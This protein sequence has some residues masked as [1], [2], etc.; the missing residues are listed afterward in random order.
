MSAAGERRP[1][2]IRRKKVVHRHHGGSWKIA[3]ADFMTALMALFLVMWILSAASP[4][5]REGVAEYFRTPLVTAITGGDRSSSSA[6]VIPGGGPDPV[7]AEG[8]RA[9]ID[10][11]TQTR[12]S[13]V[14]R[15]V[16]SNLQRRIETAIQADPELRHLRSQMRFDMTREGLRIQLLDTEQRPMFDLGS[17]RVAS[18]MRG[19]LRTI[20]PLLNELPND[21]SIAGHTDSMPYA[22]G[23]RGYSNWEL[24][25]DR[26]NASRRELVAGGLDSSKLLRVS[27]FAD[28]VPL[29]EA[30]SLDPANRRIELLVLFPRVSEQIRDPALIAEGGA[31]LGPRPSDV[32]LASVVAFQENLRQALGSESGAAARQ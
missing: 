16:F 31:S 2:I 17:D 11:R 12:P 20:S 14:Q 23:Y 22:G 5:Q 25:N 21:L 19:L 18:Y 1:I 27:G 6:S 13:D 30:D 10:M 28:R 15:L 7:H 32:D 24:S 29:P 9:R 26:A 3:L 8:E 4:E